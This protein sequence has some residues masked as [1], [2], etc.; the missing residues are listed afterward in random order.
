MI[1]DPVTDVV[2]EQMAAGD[3]EPVSTPAVGDLPA[4]KEEVDQ[5]GGLVKVDE[6]IGEA[7]K[8]EEGAQSVTEDTKDESAS[9]ETATAVMEEPRVE[10]SKP[11][12]EPMIMPR[13]ETSGQPIMEERKQE[14][15]ENPL[16]NLEVVGNR[17]N[18]S[19]FW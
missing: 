14:R 10:E 17:Y 11:E 7:K 3:A 16:Y 8:E 15:V 9:G 18:P 6:L 4:K 5:P 2:P 12:E 19:N 1:E 13:T